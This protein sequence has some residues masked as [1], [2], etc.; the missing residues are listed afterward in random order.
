MNYLVDF[1]DEASADLARMFRNEP[2]AYKKL[3][4]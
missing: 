1:T 3:K 4:N 2:K